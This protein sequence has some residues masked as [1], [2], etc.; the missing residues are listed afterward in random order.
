MPKMEEDKG[1]VVVEEQ[2]IN[3][4]AVAEK[5]VVP[6]KPD[7]ED[8]LPL[9]PELKEVKTEVVVV[10]PSIKEAPVEAHPAIKPTLAI[11]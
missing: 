4:E 1:E 7:I 9:K 10:E 2:A 11:D 8:I 5:E 6:I 3:E